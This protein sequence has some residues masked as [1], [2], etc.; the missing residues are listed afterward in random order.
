MIIF[1]ELNNTVVTLR[2]NLMFERWY[3]R[4][5]G[6]KLL[7]C[8]IVTYNVILVNIYH[9]FLTVRFITMCHAG[10]KV[11]FSCYPGMQVMKQNVTL[12]WRAF[13][14]YATWIL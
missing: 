7:L 8:L 13:Y 6:I 4:F 3:S 10:T 9:W 2:Y 11:T 12:F 14:F 1:Y 5:N